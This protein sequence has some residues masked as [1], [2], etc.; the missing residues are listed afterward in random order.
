PEREQAP[1]WGPHDSSGANGEGG[2]RLRAGV[3]IDLGPGNTLVYGARAGLVIDEPSAIALA[4]ATGKVTAVGE[5]ADVLAGKEP[6]GVDVIHP[7]REGVGAARD[8]G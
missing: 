1:W 3:G 7:L 5:G 4:R 6:Q 8:G 2:M